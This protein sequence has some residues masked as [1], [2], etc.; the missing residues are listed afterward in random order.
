MAY[1]KLPNIRRQLAHTIGRHVA[2][3]WSKGTN[4]RERL[5]ISSLGDENN[6]S[7]QSEVWWGFLIEGTSSETISAFYEL[8]VIPTSAH[9]TFERTMYWFIWSFWEQLLSKVAKSYI[10]GVST[11][12]Y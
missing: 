5:P 8:V 3:K 2:E 11:A 7:E 6:K 10:L 12:C 1:S 9:N 4:K